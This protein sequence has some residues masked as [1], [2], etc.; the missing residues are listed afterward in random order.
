MYVYQRSLPPLVQGKN[1]WDPGQFVGM[2]YL[3][4]MRSTAKWKKVRLRMQQARQCV[5]GT[6]VFSTAW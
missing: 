4:R 5:G 6:Y 3:Q 1:V 2:L